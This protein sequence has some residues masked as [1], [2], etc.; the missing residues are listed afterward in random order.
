LTSIQ[1]IINL[2]GEKKKLVKLNLSITIFGKLL[3]KKVG[4]V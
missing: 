4:Q 2:G 1:T 3:K